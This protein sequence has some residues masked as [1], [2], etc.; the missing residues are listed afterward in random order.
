MQFRIALT[1]GAGRVQGTQSV[2]S[3]ATPGPQRGHRIAIQIGGSRVVCLDPRAARGGL[4]ARQMARYF[5]IH[6]AS[7]R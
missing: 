7:L 3:G 6:P 2:H 5:D 4:Y 1:G